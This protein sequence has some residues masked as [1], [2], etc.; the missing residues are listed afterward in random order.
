MYFIDWKR[1]NPYEFKDSDYDEL[2]NS[3]LLFA[4]KFNFDKNPNIIM[5]IL[6]T[7]TR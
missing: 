6:E 4:R 3:N 5:R 1:G 2:I 7:V